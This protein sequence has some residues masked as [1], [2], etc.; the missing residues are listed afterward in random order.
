MIENKRIIDIELKAVLAAHKEIDPITPSVDEVVQFLYTLIDVRFFY[1]ALSLYDD[2]L[3]KYPYLH[4]TDFVQTF[5]KVL[6]EQFNRVYSE[7]ELFKHNE[8]K[9]QTI[10]DCFF[11]A[12][13]GDA[14]S[15][16]ELANIDY[17][18]P[19]MN[20]QIY[21]LKKAADQNFRIAQY[22]L[23]KFYREGTYVIQNDKKAFEYFFMSAMRQYIPAISQL[24]FM[25]Y[26]GYG[27]KQD[28][29]KAYHFLNNAYMK[30]YHVHALELAQLLTK[31]LGT[32]QD[33]E[34]AN[35]ILNNHQQFQQ[36]LDRT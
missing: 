22:D 23:A 19:I 1:Q 13:A 33:V 9:R 15:C 32:K 6:L 31:G 7:D 27:V 3:K 12:M 34:R 28:Y 4:L 8:E 2:Y 5:K 18:W 14:K 24:G 11:K 36:N 35:A 25:Y 26:K 17:P 10:N 29:D 30:G 16:Y 21:F 20:T